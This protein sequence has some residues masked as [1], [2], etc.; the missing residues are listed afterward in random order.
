MNTWAGTPELE[1]IFSICMFISCFILKISLMCHILI[2]HF[3]LQL[4]LVHML[5]LFQLSVFPA[6]DLHQLFFLPLTFSFFLFPASFTCI[7]IQL[8]IIKPRSTPY[9]PQN[10][11]EPCV[12]FKNF[13]ARD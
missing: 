11:M 12:F 1:L 6:C 13:I 10:K 9:L 2:L 7:W 4:V 5:P 8:Y 3:L